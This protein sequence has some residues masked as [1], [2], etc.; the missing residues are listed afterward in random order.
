M[1]PI[2]RLLF[3]AHYV[4]EDTWLMYFSLAMAEIETVAVS[5]PSISDSSTV[6]KGGV[7]E[8]TFYH[9]KYR[10]YFEVVDE[11]DKNLK[12]CCTLCSPSSKPLCCA[13]NTTSN[14]KKHLDSVHKMVN[15][16]AILPES[17]G[18]GKQKR[19]AG[20]NGDSCSKRQ[21]TLDRKGVSSVEVRKLVTEYIID[22][23]LPLTT[24]ESPAFKMLIDSFSPRPVQLPDRK[25][26]CSHIEQAYESM[27][28][29]IKENPAE[30]E[31]VSTT[32]DVWTAYHKSYLG[33]MVHWINEK[34]LKR[35]KAAIACIRIVGRHTYDILAA[36]IEEVHISFALH[37]KNS[38][39][40]T[41]NGSNFIKA[42]TTFSVP[43]TALDDNEEHSITDDD[44]MV[45]NDDVTFTDLNDA[46]TPYPNEDD[47]L[48]QIE[49]ELPPHQRCA[50]H[51]LNLVAS[52]DVDEHLLS[53]SHSKNVYRSSFGTME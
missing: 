9:W 1:L 10:H 36:K 34:S 4:C 17:V 41:D 3:D 19:P 24:V 16:V 20:D 42:F 53:C 45:L 21:A 46:I 6:S 23:M 14:F 5:S 50:S 31:K 39:T 15:L 51:T 30:V 22:D 25:T 11:S 28:K 27:M 32:A 40:V 47:D 35:D 13:R 48:T 33:M 43:D 29:K 7:K 44:D 18:G 37:G 8:A 52:T 2:I 26:I 12:V 49:Y 38:S